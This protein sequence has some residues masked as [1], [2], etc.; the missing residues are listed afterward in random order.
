MNNIEGKGCVSDMI[1][2]SRDMSESSTL[3][4]KNKPDNIVKTFST[5]GGF[6]HEVK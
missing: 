5:A 6:K 4:F 1:L 3:E 2:K